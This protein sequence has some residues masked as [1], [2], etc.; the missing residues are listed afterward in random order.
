MCMSNNCSDPNV[1]SN[2]QVNHSLTDKNNELLNT[3]MQRIKTHN[4][5][6]HTKYHISSPQLFKG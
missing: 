1:N 5:D 4:D 3:C 6:I 2:F